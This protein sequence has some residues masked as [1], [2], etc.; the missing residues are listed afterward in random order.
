MIPVTTYNDEGIPPNAIC[1][2]IIKAF[3]VVPYKATYAFNS[4]T[5]QKTV[6]T[7]DIEQ[8]PFACIDTEL[9]DALFG[10]WYGFIPA[11]VPTDRQGH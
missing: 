3:G 10:A 2:A 9:E 8:N 4:N 11:R 1:T 6:E 5:E 7:V